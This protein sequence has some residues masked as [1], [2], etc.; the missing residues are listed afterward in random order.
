MS[1]LPSLRLA[2]LRH[3]SAW[4][5]IQARAREILGRHSI[6]LPVELGD[7]E[8]A[9]TVEFLSLLF[10][11]P[12]R[13]LPRFADLVVLSAEVLASGA[14]LILLI[15]EAISVDAKEPVP[16]NRL[17]INTVIVYQATRSPQDLVL[18][19]PH[20]LHLLRDL[21]ADCL[22]REQ[23]DLM[24]YI[25]SWL[26]IVS[27]SPRTA[28]AFANAALTHAAVLPT[29]EKYEIYA[30]GLSAT[31]AELLRGVD[32]RIGEW[33]LAH[34]LRG[35]FA[36]SLVSSD[37][38]QYGR[39]EA[40]R[41][42]LELGLA[43]A[44]TFDD[45]GEIDQPILRWPLRTLSQEEVPMPVR[46]AEFERFLLPQ[47]SV[48]LQLVLRR[49]N[50]VTPRLTGLAGV[51]PIRT[52]VGR[53]DLLQRLARLLEPK[54]IIKIALLYGP[55][56]IGKSA[57]AAQLTRMMEHIYQPIWLR[58]GRSPRT[59]WLQVADAMGL[60]P[61]SPD[62]PTRMPAWFSQILDR[63][64]SNEYL[65]VVDDVEETPASELLKWLP[66]NGP[67][68]CA[69]LILS[70]RMIPLTQREFGAV[71]VVLNS[72][73]ESEGQ[74]LFGYLLDEFP[75]TSPPIARQGLLHMAEG[76]PLRLRQVYWRAVQGVP[77]EQIVQTLLR[78]NVIL[79]LKLAEED[80]LPETVLAD[81]LPEEV[82][83]SRR[84]M[85]LSEC[86]FI[87]RDEDALRLNPPSAQ[88]VR[89][90][91]PSAFAFISPIPARFVDVIVSHMG[92]ALASKDLLAQRRLLPHLKRALTAL[93]SKSSDSQNSLLVTVAYSNEQRYSLIARM[94]RYLQRC[95]SGDP[96]ENQRLAAQA[97]AFLPEGARTVTGSPSEA[98]P[99]PVL[100][101]AAL[102][103][104]GVQQTG[105]VNRAMLRDSL[106]K[107]LPTD[108]ELDAFLLDHFPNVW[109]RFSAGMDRNTKINLLLELVDPEVLF[110]RLLVWHP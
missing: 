12:V 7:E 40:L 20:E 14:P 59:A 71:S 27:D 110:K 26:G 74:E 86:G 6:P 89:Q 107:L 9:S 58:F 49:A 32:D 39:T 24:R 79:C 60:A 57:T 47:L 68:R 38:V 94:A 80:L 76:N 35:R 43:E 85:D 30:T 48:P 64:R 52:F 23:I 2:F 21:I 29:S 8:I 72:L 109:H 101:G 34:G 5:E 11:A 56:G 3:F 31:I 65:I 16:G 105:A 81:C 83:L 108:S 50:E 99:V 87:E 55:G 102:E 19:L 106:R 22:G 82:A 13:A 54:D 33:V 93:L 45:R 4:S 44:L 61:T 42:A 62:P 15:H 28:I 95:A 75:S 98:S 51:L 90:R 1:H 17:G 10:D 67:G 66:P 103:G 46:L 97:L 53:S 96:L 73:T 91:A 25:A 70:E 78:D 37:A 41:R 104:R 18:S 92:S 84:I 88:L 63:L 100:Q 77:P 69:V 36:A